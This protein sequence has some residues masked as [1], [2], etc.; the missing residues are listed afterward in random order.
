METIKLN[1]FFP[2]NTQ[3]T[4]L[5][6]SKLYQLVVTSPIL[7]P[8]I[9]FALF[10]LLIRRL[11][12]YPFVSSK[13]VPIEISRDWADKLTSTLHATVVSVAAGHW[14]WYHIIHDYDY[15][16]GKASGNWR[17]TYSSDSAWII[18]WTI[19][20]L[21]MDSIR[22]LGK[23]LRLWEIIVSPL[24]STSTTLSTLSPSSTSSSSSI[25]SS[26]SETSPERTAKTTTTTTS[27]SPS[28]SSSSSTSSSVMLFHHILVMIILASGLYY[29]IGVPYMV[30]FLLNEISTP[31]LNMR[32]ILSQLG[33]KSHKIYLVNDLI[34]MILFAI[35]RVM[36]NFYLLYDV[37]HEMGFITRLKS[38]SYYNKHG[39]PKLTS[40]ERQVLIILTIGGTVQFLLQVY[41]MALILRMVI[42]KMKLKKSI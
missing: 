6:I 31:F 3:I 40:N 24:P 8:A 32:F 35:M 38:S 42:R 2:V 15:H 34:F 29:R 11:T 7:S 18:N 13:S 20:Y 22:I 9:S 39:V 33:Y 16:Y 17:W 36:V 19:G 5:S 23:M 4:S 14:I 10:Y 12:S 26:S 28:S 25:S 1:T 30:I 37:N 21:L 41:W 27:P